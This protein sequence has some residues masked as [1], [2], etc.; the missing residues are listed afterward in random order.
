MNEHDNL[1]HTVIGVMQRDSIDM[2]FWHEATLEDTSIRGGTLRVPWELLCSSWG[3]SDRDSPSLRTL[4]SR[5]SRQGRGQEWRT[6]VAQLGGM[7][8]PRRGH[9]SDRGHKTRAILVE[10]RSNST[11]AIGVRLSPRR[12]RRRVLRSRRGRYCRRR[13]RRFR[14]DALLRQQHLATRHHRRGRYPML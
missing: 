12:L 3:G 2:R 4:G 14:R 5:L 10:L 7:S 11:N 9:E 13:L 8:P 1:S 6:A